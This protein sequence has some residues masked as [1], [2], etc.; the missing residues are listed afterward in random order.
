MSNGGMASATQARMN[1]LQHIQVNSDWWITCCGIV[2]AFAP[3]SW[4]GAC[5]LGRVQRC[6][7][8]NH[9]ACWPSFCVID[10]VHAFHDI[11]QGDLEALRAEINSLR[12]SIKKGAE[13]A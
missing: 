11:M 10:H 7:G 12:A 2:C 5:L 1:P 9:A 4:A 8:L 13:A 6:L 3:W